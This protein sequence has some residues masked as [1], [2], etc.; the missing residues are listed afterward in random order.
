MNHLKL[1]PS[2]YADCMMATNVRTP[3]YK[4]HVEIGGL[5]NN[6]TILLIMGIGAQH[7]AWPTEFCK[8][9]I[10]GGYRVIRFDNRDIGKSSKIKH[11]NK[12]TKHFAQPLRQMWLASRFQVGLSNQKLPL[13]YDLYDMAE[14]VRQLLQAMEIARCHIIGMS[15]GGM[16]AQ[17]LSAKHPQIVASLGLIATSNNRPFS[18]PPNPR[19][20]MKAA[21]PPK[22][23]KPDVAIEH[24]YNTLRT[25][26]SSAYFDPLAAQKKAKMLYKRRFYPK[27]VRRHV[28]A[29][30][31]TGSLRKINQQIKQ[32]T[33]VLHGEQDKII[34]ISQGRGV[35][36]NIPNA[37]FVSI[38]N[39]GHEIPIAIAE[40]I[41]GY[42]LTHFNW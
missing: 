27:G 15:M 35:A 22:S 17:I 21:R 18:R 38:P 28:L 42:F 8:A 13:P 3:K 32:P 19:H 5:D 40:D 7:L 10:D 39:M 9:L 4:F 24:I 36:K 29:V 12:V 6:K 16:I 30:L 2:K 34:P 23:K 11:K 25:V 14:D 20:I 37:R 1:K 26:S 31:A 41:A 33:L